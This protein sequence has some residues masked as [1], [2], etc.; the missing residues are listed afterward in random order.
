MAD[1]DGAWDDFLG[2]SAQ[3][4]VDWK[5]EVEAVRTQVLDWAAAALRA[6]QPSAAAFR[7]PKGLVQCRLDLDR[8][9]KQ[10]LRTES[11]LDRAAWRK[12]MMATVF[13][14][15]GQTER[16]LDA[17]VAVLVEAL[18]RLTPWPA[19]LTAAQAALDELGCSHRETLRL[20]AQRTVAG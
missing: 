2:G 1:D 11:G 16:E 17:G 19:A 20:V 9:L 13:A 5:A 6:R 10:I 4:A 18:I 7:G 14:P 8:M 3:D 15:R 12:W